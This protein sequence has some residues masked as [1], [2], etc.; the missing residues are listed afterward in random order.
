MIPLA[1]RVRPKKFEDIIGQDEVIGEG[2]ILRAMIENDNLTSMILWG[3]PGCGKTSLANIIAKTS[4]REFFNLRATYVGIKEIKELIEK[5]KSNNLF[6]QKPPIVFLDEIHRFAKNQQD[7]LLDAVERQVFILIGATTE[8]PSFE[9][10]PPLLSRCH[11]F[12]LKQ[13]DFND[14]K[15]I[16]I[17]TINS[18]EIIKEKVKIEEF[19]NLIYYSGGDARRLLNLIEII[20]LSAK[21][22]PVIINNQLIESVIKKNFLKYDKKSDYHYDTISAF[23]KSVRGSDPNAA[24]FYLAKMLQS[25]ED[26]EFICRRLLILA[27][28]DVGLANP[29]AL[30]VANSAFEAIQKVGMPEAQIILSQLT[31][32]LACS[33]KSN[34]AYLAIKKANEYV[35]LYGHLLIP[36]HIRNAP[37]RL[38]QE[39]QYHK[40]YLYPHDYENNFVYQNYLPQEIENLKLY[41]PQD[42]S[43]ERK[44]RKFLNKCWGNKYNY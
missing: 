1:E 12:V 15:R 19:E 21:K 38:L 41:E 25:G 27:S 40:G 39:L 26:I 20:F 2:S 32:Y 3:P 44:Y 33:P 7:A 31:I 36:L 28:E 18:D 11:V 37:T 42:N 23:I 34:S 4:N 24:L 8:N 29:M 22:F 17:K 14:L 5:I 13:L 9:I 30:V 10:I 43:I 6:Y 16:A 35:H